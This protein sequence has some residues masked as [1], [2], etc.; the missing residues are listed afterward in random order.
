MGVGSRV[1][2]GVGDGTGLEVTATTGN[3]PDTANTKTIANSK[4]IS[5]RM[6]V[7]FL[8]VCIL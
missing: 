4:P 3:E 5:F 6:E 8:K 1:A 2:V 7:N